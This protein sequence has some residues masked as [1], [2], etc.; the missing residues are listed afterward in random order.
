MSS[1]ILG[2]NEKGEIDPEFRF[3][4]D[5]ARQSNILVAETAL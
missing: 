4:P 5:L 1:G 2:L 3:Y